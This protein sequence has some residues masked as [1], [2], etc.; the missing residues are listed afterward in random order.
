MKL[1]DCILAGQWFDK[2]KQKTK[3]WEILTPTWSPTCSSCASY[4]PWSRIMGWRCGRLQARKIFEGAFKCIK[5]QMAYFAFGGGPRICIG[6]S[7]GLIEAKIAVDMILQHFSFE[8]SPS[9]IHSPITV[10]TN[11]PKH[12]AQII[13]H[14]LLSTSNIWDRR[15]HCCRIFLW[16]SS[17]KVIIKVNLVSSCRIG[18]SVYFL[19]FQNGRWKFISCQ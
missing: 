11:Q 16:L 6:Q 4:S 13:L 8:L 15:V 2:N 7:F 12:G 14:K 10:V 1:W 3:P 19:L 5:A 9:Y 17:M 18:I